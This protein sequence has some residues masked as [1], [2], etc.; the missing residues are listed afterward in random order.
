LGAYAAVDAKVNTVCTSVLTTDMELL[1]LWMIAVLVPMKV[2]DEVP[3]SR[4]C[5]GS[6]ARAACGAGCHGE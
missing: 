2:M 4:R 1:T 6:H 3:S 5:H